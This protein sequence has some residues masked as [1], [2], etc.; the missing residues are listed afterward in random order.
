[1]KASVNK[2]NLLK[3]GVN[4][5]VKLFLFVIVF[6]FMLVANYIAYKN[7]PSKINVNPSLA[8]IVMLLQLRVVTVVYQIT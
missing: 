8:V 5:L 3:I 4:Y 7:L 2:C 6:L 1:M